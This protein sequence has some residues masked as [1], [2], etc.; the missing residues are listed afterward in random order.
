MDS[1]RERETLASS[2][3][4]SMKILLPTQASFG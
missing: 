1:L 4:L 3:F 2:T